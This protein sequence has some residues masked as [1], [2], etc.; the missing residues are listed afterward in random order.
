M[1]RKRAHRRRPPLRVPEALLTAIGPVDVARV[2]RSVSRLQAGLTRRDPKFIRGYFED[3]A[4][5]EAYAQYYVCTNA[6]KLWPVLDRLWGAEPPEAPRVLELGCGPGTGVAAFGLWAQ[7]HLQSWSHL[8]TDRIEANLRASRALA[9]RLDLPVECALLDLAAPLRPP[10][11]FDLVL[12][13][14]VVN[15]LGEGTLQRLANDLARLDCPVLVIEPAAKA[16]SR[17]ALSFRD[18]LLREGLNPLLPCTHALPCPALAQEDAWC[19]AEWPYERPDFV[20][21]VDRQVGTRREVLKA[22]VFAMAPRSPLEPGAS[23]VV[24]DTFREKGRSHLLVC[25]AEGLRRVELQRRDARAENAAFG[26]VGR[27]DRVR[28]EGLVQIGERWRLGP[29]ST[30]VRS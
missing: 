1:G 18:A 28:M 27:H 24:S 8:A 26:E 11:A 16:P 13:M 10:G 3:R 4:L 6:P 7:E 23:C 17:R 19:H 2:A 15:E 5:R 21:A 12:A 14:N 22:T 29:G 25:D 20:A 30:C 9:G